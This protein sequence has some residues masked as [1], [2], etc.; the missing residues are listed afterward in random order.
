MQIVMTQSSHH[1]CALFHLDM[2]AV[3]VLHLILDLFHDGGQR[4]GILGRVEVKQGWGLR[5]IEW[6]IIVEGNAR[7]M[8]QVTD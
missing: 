3:D 6:D 7:D 8:N 5:E 2:I 1:V 4:D